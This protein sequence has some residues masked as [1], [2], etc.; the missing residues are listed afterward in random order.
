L[1]L[2]QVEI[3]ELGRFGGTGDKP[4]LFK[5]PTAIDISQ[6][7][8]IF[9][10]DRGNNRIQVFNLNGEF[11]KDIGGFGWKNDQ[12][13]EPLDIWA[14]STL[15]IYVADY[16]NQRVQR[17]DKDLNFIDSFFSNEGNDERY[18]FKEI[19]SVAYSP[20]GDLFIL[21]AG[22]NKVVKFNSENKGEVAFGYYESGIGELITPTQ[23]D[24]TANHRIIVSDS[25]S[26]GI[27]VF[28]YFGTFLRKIEHP[29]FKF[30]T[31]LAVDEKGRIFVTD[32]EARQ[33]FIFS[34]EGKFMGKWES[35][36]GITLKDPVDIAIFSYQQQ[37][38]IY[39]IDGDYII[40]ASLKFT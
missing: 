13:D 18:Q 8:Q 20:Q 38:H 40:I 21:D 2:G 28:D 22:E 26:R 7:G 16:N 27:F 24:L 29:L 12:F 32:P 5:N 15:N 1:L 4:S 11:I 31:G 6:S 19:L 39:L 3:T 35:I 30:P 23:L 25:K 9:V 10:C 14:K 34:T 37:Y 33:V 17:Y 36:G